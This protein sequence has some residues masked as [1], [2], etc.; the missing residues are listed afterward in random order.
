LIIMGPTEGISAQQQIVPQLAALEARLP[1]HID[2]VVGSR[3]SAT[4]ARHFSPRA[5]ECCRIAI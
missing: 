2:P 5:C 3:Q 4:Q 1:P